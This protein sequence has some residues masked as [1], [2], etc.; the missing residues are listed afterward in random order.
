MSTATHVDRVLTYYDTHPI[1]EQQ[2]LEHLQRR[3]LSPDG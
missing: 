1:N 2:I 3:G